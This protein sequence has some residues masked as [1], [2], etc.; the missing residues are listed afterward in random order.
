MSQLLGAELAFERQLSGPSEMPSAER[1]TL[2]NVGPTP[3]TDECKGEEAQ[4]HSLIWD[5][6]GSPSH[7]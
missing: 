6:S 5:N 7:P 2:T 3:V 4:P 1:A